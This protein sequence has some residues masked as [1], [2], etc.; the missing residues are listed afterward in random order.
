MSNRLHQ[1]IPAAALAWALAGFAGGVLAQTAPDNGPADAGPASHDPGNEGEAPRG[2]HGGEGGWQHHW[3]HHRHHHRW[4]HRWGHGWGG[5]H[6]GA[7]GQGAMLMRSFRGLNLTAAQREQLHTILY[8]SRQGNPGMH[9]GGMPDMM[10]LAN[11]GDPNY[12]AALAA[13]KK[14][15]TD[16]IQKDSDL[17]LQLYNVL[18]ADQKAQLTNNLAAWKARMAQRGPGPTARASSGCE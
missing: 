4:G 6:D 3:H 5:E 14:R 17:R 9:A 16:R 10:A 18:T 12:A 11:P 15:A 13:A 2:E 1:F 8:K 7:G